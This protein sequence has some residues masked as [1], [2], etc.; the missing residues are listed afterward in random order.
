MKTQLLSL[1]L[2]LLIH[3]GLFFL[4]RPPAPTTVVT[5][6]L[7][8]LLQPQAQP[9]T[10]AAPAIVTQP[11]PNRP[12]PAARAISSPVAPRKQPASAVAEKNTLPAESPPTPVLNTSVKGL[13]S[14]PDAH[15]T[16]RKP[17]PNMAA[18]EEAR[19][20]PLAKSL[21]KAV[22][23]DCKTAHANLGLL[24]IV[25]LALDAATDSGCQW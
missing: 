17:L 25:P 2:A 12:L 14:E 22:R 1:A 15:F 18:P 21:D 5:A 8:V 13:L 11:A 4:Y 3:M 24:A 23:P 19:R 16:A 6:P 7:Q 10:A 20:S 9:L